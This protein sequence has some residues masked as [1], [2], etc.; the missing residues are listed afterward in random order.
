MPDQLS[1]QP[2]QPQELQRAEPTII[3]LIRE[4]TTNPAADVS[5]LERLIA[6]QERAQSQQAATAFAVAM[7]AAQEEME[8]VRRDAKNSHTGSQ[9]AKLETIDAAIRP[10]YTRNGFSLSFN[11]PQTEGDN[12]TVACTV[13]HDAGHSR[14]YSLSGSLDGAGA[15]GASNKTP[16]QALGSTVTYLRRYLECM[17][18]N[19]Q[20]GGEDNDGNVGKKSA[21]ISQEQSDNLRDFAR[22]IGLNPQQESNW[23]KML[24]AKTIPEIPATHYMVA[25]RMLQARAAAKGGK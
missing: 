1:L 18:F 21:F 22:E 7:K 8:P 3:D 10:V 19:V 5:K 12:V 6:L 23:L 15:K 14:D 16:I 2:A 20:L 4:V 13:F 9:Y 17:I 24:D 11:S 25:Y